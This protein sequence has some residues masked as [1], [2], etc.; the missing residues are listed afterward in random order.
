MSIVAMLPLSVSVPGRRG[1][2]SK[3]NLWKGLD[4]RDQAFVLAT[5]TCHVRVETLNLD[6]L[7]S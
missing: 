7:L 1:D 6:G 5:H 3:T 2:A 4:W